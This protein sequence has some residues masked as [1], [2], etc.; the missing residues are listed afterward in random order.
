MHMVTVRDHKSVLVAF[1]LMIHQRFLSNPQSS[2]SFHF[3]PFS[4]PPQPAIGSRSRRLPS[5]PCNKP[6]CFLSHSLQHI[7]DLH[8]RS[9]KR[10]AFVAFPSPP[11]YRSSLCYNSSKAPHPLQ[12]HHPTVCLTSTNS[13]AL[14]IHPITSTL[15]VVKLLQIV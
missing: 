5:R 6:S 8:Q 12:Y 13:L 9:A 15:P 3:P 4:S 14:L 7:T 11:P 10:L 1:L 2:V